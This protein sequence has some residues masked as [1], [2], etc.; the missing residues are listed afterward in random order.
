[1]MP[2]QEIGVDKLLTTILSAVDEI[3]KE[4]YIDEDRIGAVGASYGGYSV[5][6]LAGMHE[7]RFATFISHCGLFNLDSWYGDDR[8]VIFCQS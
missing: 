6:Y 3:K 2:F 8:R 1:M 5:Y 7:N 4:K